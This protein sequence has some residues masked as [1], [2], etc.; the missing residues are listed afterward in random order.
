MLKKNQKSLLLLFVTGVTCHSSREYQPGFPWSDFVSETPVRRIQYETIRKGNGIDASV[1]ERAM[2]VVIT[3]TPAA[4]WPI[5]KWT[6][7]VIQQRVKRLTNVYDGPEELFLYYHDDSPHED[8]V[9]AHAARGWKP[10]YVLKNMSTTQFFEQCERMQRRGR[11]VRS[12]QEDHRYYYFSGDL[13]IWND[14]SLVRD[15]SI[16]SDLPSAAKALFSVPETHRAKNVPEQEPIVWIACD[17]VTAA[18]HYDAVHNFFFQ[19]YGEKSFVLFPPSAFAG[20]HMHPTSHPSWT[21]SQVA[22]LMAVDIERFPFFPLIDRAYT[23][24]LQP[25]EM[26][27]LPPF[28]F[29]RVKALGVSI[30]LALWSDSSVV[31]LVTSANSRAIPFEPDWKPRFKWAG[32][33]RYI[34]L[35]AIHYFRA[36]DKDPDPVAAARR[37]IHLLPATRYSRPC[38]RAAAIDSRCAVDR[39][40]KGLED[41]F[42]RFAEDHAKA[43]VDMDPEAVGHFKLLDFFDDLASWG[44][45]DADASVYLGVSQ[46]T[47]ATRNA[48]CEL[49]PEADD[50]AQ[51]D[52]RPLGGSGDGSSSLTPAGATDASDGGVVELVCWALTHCFP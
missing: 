5:A 10:Q 48:S 42:Q 43:F 15:P 35:L 34:A 50:E 16:V 19:I 44:S 40:A 41:K 23:V 22:D 11:G 36:K 31:D 39:I 32:A 37:L 25:G 12:E 13:G 46:T 24:T 52:E 27:Y 28:W 3:G 18:A 4:A 7:D 45:S 17:N 49:H 21:Q 47:A 33:A 8:H 1:F 9:E 6:P 2:P 20:M 26:L 14:P 38:R 51:N 30:S 29:H